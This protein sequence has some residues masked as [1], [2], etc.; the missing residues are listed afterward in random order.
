MDI[1]WNI[2]E[3][4]PMRVMESCTLYIEPEKKAIF[5]I[6]GLKE[7]GIESTVP[8]LS[9]FRLYV[10][11]TNELPG[12][13]LPITYLDILVSCAPRGHGAGAFVALWVCGNELETGRIALALPLL[14]GIAF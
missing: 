2:V 8:K 3:S 12:I 1:S 6:A 13:W 11:K 5:P 9:I 10:E 7:S 4:E 14:N